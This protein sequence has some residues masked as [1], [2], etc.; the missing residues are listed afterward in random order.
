MNNDDLIKIIA[1]KSFKELHDFNKK[2]NDIHEARVSVFLQHLENGN[3]SEFIKSLDLVDFNSSRIWSKILDINIGKLD[4]NFIEAIFQKDYSL[5]KVSVSNLNNTIITKLK[6]LNIQ[7]SEEY[8]PMFLIREVIKDKVSS[9]VFFAGAMQLP[10]NDE[11]FNTAIKVL[12]K[13]KIL[14]LADNMLSRLAKRDISSNC[15]SIHK[16]I[17]D[18]NLSVKFLSKINTKENLEYFFSVPNYRKAIL[19]E[20]ISSIIK[21]ATAQADLSKMNFFYELGYPL[22]EDKQT[23]SALF[24][25]TKQEAS[26]AQLFVISRVSDITIHNQIILKTLLHQGYSDHKESRTKLVQET[27]KKYSPEQIET[28]P[29]ALKGRDDTQNVLLVKKFLEYHS[30]NKTLNQPNDLTETKTTKLKI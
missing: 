14:S 28:L 2:I 19:K 11:V 21:D 24:S 26:E 16:F 15:D 4:D 6:K 3:T 17:V 29:I 18:N 9:N 20:D 30:L 27:I 25:K 5:D 22:C 23:Y 7:K 10:F 8:E 13:E 1:N 12:G